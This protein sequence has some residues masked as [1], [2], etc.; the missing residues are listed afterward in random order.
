[1]F[2]D[3]CRFQHYHKLCTRKVCRESQ[4]KFRHPTS[5]K[6]GEY[7]KFLKKKGC[8]Y[9]HIDMKNDEVEISNR[10]NKDLETEV[11]NLKVEIKDLKSCIILKEK[12]LHKM[13][14]EEEKCTIVYFQK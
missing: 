12:E 2:G 14:V 1:M 5:C 7:C 9:K 8:I 13:S 10:L 11:D 6:F 3:Q 4:C